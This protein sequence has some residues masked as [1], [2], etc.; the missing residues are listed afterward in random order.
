MRTVI[1][2]G[3]LLIADAIRGTITLPYNQN[4]IGFI[5]V[6]LLASII[7]DITDVVRGKEK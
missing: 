2:M 7:M 3:A 1:L 6:V 4:T 5:A